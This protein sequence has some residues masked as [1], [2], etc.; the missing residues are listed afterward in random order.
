M[1]TVAILIIALIFIGCNSKSQS[2]NDRQDIRNAMNKMSKLIIEK[3]YAPVYDMS[4]P[5]SYGNSSKEEVLKDLNSLIYDE[6]YRLEIKNINI[7]SISEVYSENSNK[8]A[9]VDYSTAATL[10]F[11]LLP[12][13]D[14]VQ[15]LDRFNQFCSNGKQQVN[16]ETLFSCDYSKKSAFYKQKDFSFF[17]YKQQD[18]KWYVLNT[19]GLEKVPNAIP[20]TI[21][22]KLIK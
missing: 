12:N 7:D 20:E 6:G 22:K 5:G 13:E 10:W 2:V 11:K 17:I 4:Y 8:Y 1:K 9:R 18:K 14:S 21:F 15:M 3:D 16:D 19:G